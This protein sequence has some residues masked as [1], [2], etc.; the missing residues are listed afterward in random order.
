MDKQSCNASRFATL[1][2]DEECMKATGRKGKMA[3]P[4]DISIFRLKCQVN[5]KYCPEGVGCVGSRESCSGNK[6]LDVPLGAQPSA[7]KRFFCRLR[8][9][10]CPRYFQS[11][12]TIL[13]FL[14][15]SSD[16][17]YFASEQSAF[18]RFQMPP[19]TSQFNYS[20]SYGLSITALRS[21]TQ[22]YFCF[23]TEEALWSV[24][25]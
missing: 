18:G 7:E 21:I 4:S 3:A 2:C 8:D 13:C 15:A 16:V 23:A 1:P 5:E 6:R 20:Y 10:I 12:P 22:L 17:N 14:D 11:S 25:L 19:M 24:E 9:Y